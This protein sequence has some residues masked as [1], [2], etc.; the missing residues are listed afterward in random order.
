LEFWNIITVNNEELK[1][2]TINECLFTNKTKKYF[3]LAEN[4]LDNQ[5]PSNNYINSGTN[6]NYDSISK[7]NLDNNKYDEKDSQL[8]S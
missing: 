1:L 8:S 5:I 2:E 7:A 4:E 3:N 6:E